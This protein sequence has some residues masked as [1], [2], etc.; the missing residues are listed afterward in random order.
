MTTKIATLACKNCGSHASC[1]LT[2]GRYNRRRDYHVGE[3]RLTGAAKDKFI[4]GN[5]DGTVVAQCKACTS[6]NVAV[7]VEERSQ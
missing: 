2:R 7:A 3:G 6:F 4:V 1:K 5:Y